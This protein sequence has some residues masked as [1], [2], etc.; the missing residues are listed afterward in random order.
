MEFKKFA[1]EPEAGFRDSSYY[2]DSPS[3]AR[4]VLQRQHDM[5]RDYI[6]SL[7]DA[8]ASGKEGESGIEHIG[9]P[10]I[11]GLEGNNVYEQLSSLKKQ[12]T[13][14]VGGAIPDGSVEG[15]KLADG[16]VKGSKISDGEIEDRHFKENAKIA[17]AEKA[18]T[19]DGHKAEEFSPVKLTGV[20]CGFRERVTSEKITSVKG[21]TFNNK[22]YMNQENG[23][24]LEL[25]PETGALS[26]FL[27]F[28]DHSRS[29]RFAFDVN[30]EMYLAF[31]DRKSDYG[32]IRIFRYSDGELLKLTE[33][34]TSKVYT[35]TYDLLDMDIL[36]GYLYILTV[37]YGDNVE[38]IRLPL[39][40]I[41]SVTEAVPCYTAKEICDDLRIVIK[42]GNIYCNGR[43]FEG[44][45]ENAVS[46]FCENV[47]GDG[48][49]N[50][51]LTDGNFVFVSE[52]NL[53]EA[54]NPGTFSPS[55]SFCF[56]NYL[57]TLKSGYIFRARII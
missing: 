29:F 41:S 50:L 36:N 26:E 4:E 43:K 25:D 13:D 15:V 17:V 53:P 20:V 37:Y 38:I 27:D 44:G 35:Y 34:K 45:S 30:G 23:K 9:C 55:Q 54:T 56:G 18:E 51:M 22:R 5:T 40:D 6:N 21:K 52:N 46:T 14:Y 33:I 28:S 31:A 19:L 8:L 10:E 49:G 42:N 2:E 11:S 3:D 7:V 12:M 48:P 32:Y 1:F 47:L 16:C 57:Y 39:N 24:I